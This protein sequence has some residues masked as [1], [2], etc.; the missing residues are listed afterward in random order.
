MWK[1]LLQQLPCGEE[2]EILLAAATPAPADWQ[3]RPNLRWLHC[4]H[5]GRAAQMNHAAATA[6]K[7][8]LWFVHADSRPAANAVAQLRRSLHQAP[9][10][11]HYFALRFYDG[12][13]K[14]KLNEIGVAWRCRL[15]ANPFG[16]QALCMAKR[17]F[18]DLHGF[19]ETAPYGEDHL[20]VLRARRAKV[21]L[22]AVPAVVGTSARRY[23]QHGWWRTVCLYQKLWW[24]QWRQH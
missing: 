6:G 2:D 20:L 16:D 19:D 1:A 21:R 11:V 4:P 24:R 14:M 7:P 12:N 18:D 3:E 10:A 23:V 17:V 5:R 9:Q 15:F 22:V 13:W 8:F